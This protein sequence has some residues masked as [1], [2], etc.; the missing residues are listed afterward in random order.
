VTKDI[1]EIVRR[2]LDPNPEKR[3]TVFESLAFACE[4]VLRGISPLPP[5]EYIKIFVQDPTTFKAKLHNVSRNQNSKGHHR[6]F[7]VGASIA[8]G[9]LIAA[10]LGLALTRFVPSTKPVETQTAAPN[11]NAPVN[12]TTITTQAPEPDQKSSLPASITEN[13]AKGENQQNSAVTRAAVIASDNAKFVRSSAVP[14]QTTSQTTDA[15]ISFEQAWIAYSKKDYSKTIWILKQLDSGNLA[16]AKR[17]SATIMLLDSYFMTSAFNEAVTLGR[18]TPLNDARYYTTLALVHEALDDNAQ[19]E[20]LF[21]KAIASPSIMGKQ[22]IGE[23]ID[24]RAKFLTRR[25]QDLQSE[26]S[27]KKMIVAWQIVEREFCS[28]DSRECK[29]ARDALRT[30][31]GQAAKNE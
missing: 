3:Y 29:E 21:D 24:Q 11:N 23:A 6:K 1:S 31:A 12:S 7:I 5:E 4:K 9:L 19:A 18:N 20:V 26:E 15:V 14:Q 22:G 30:Y 27:R 25:F 17:D 16:G 28:S 10:G 13:S 2:C 8:G